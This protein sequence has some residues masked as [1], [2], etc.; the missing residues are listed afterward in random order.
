MPIIISLSVYVDISHHFHLRA[1]LLIVGSAV[2]KYKQIHYKFHFSAVY[3][4]PNANSFTFVSVSKIRTS[5]MLGLS[6]K[7]H[8]LLAR[9][10]RKLLSCT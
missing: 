2:E 5:K 7:E 6:F 9:S 8:H 3:A 10:R 4:T 1:T